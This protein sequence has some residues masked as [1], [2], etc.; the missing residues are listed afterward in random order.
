MQLLKMK[1]DALYKDFKLNKVEIRITERKADSG[2]SLTPLVDFIV[3]GQSLFERLQVKE[4]NIVGAFSPIW[5]NKDRW[6]DKGIWSRWKESKAI[7]K[8]FLRKKKSYLKEERVLIY[9]CEVCGDMG[10]G[11]R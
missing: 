4:Y 9:C 3:D 2:E 11:K 5:M 6:P 8:I 10:L 7:E 1:K